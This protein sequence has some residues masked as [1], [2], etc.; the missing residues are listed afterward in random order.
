MKIRIKKKISIYNLA[1]GFVLCLDLLS[2]YFGGSTVGFGWAS[3]L[4]NLG[5]M[6]MFA[7]ILLEYCA[8]KHFDRRT[9]RILLVGGI[10]F[11]G[12]LAVSC[13][14]GID[15]GYARKNLLTICK[16]T[17][18]EISI[19]ML[20]NS[21]HFNFFQEL[22]KN[23][24]LFNFWGFLNMIVLTIQINVKGFM[25]P[26]AWLSMNTYYE[27]LCSGLFGYNGTHRL[28]I[29]M[30]FLFLYNMYFA[31]FEIQK[32]SKQKKLYI[33]NFFLLGWHFMLSTRNDN[34]TIYMLTAI[35]FA[36]YIFMDMHWRKYPIAKTLYKCLKYVAVGLLA[37]IIVFAVPTTREFIMD[38]V[39]KRIMK[40]TTVTASTGSGSTERLSILLYSFENGFGYGIGKGIGYFPFGGDWETNSSVVGF[41]HFGLSS[42]SSL[43]YLLG[44]WF[45][46]FYTLW[47]TKIYQGMCRH[48]DAIFFFVILCIMLFLTF[49][50]TNFTSTP[51]STCLM[52]LFAVF[53]MME[54]KIRMDRTLWRM[55]K[56][57]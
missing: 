45:Y 9:V 21:R 50:T 37:V 14:C 51:M 31:E 3:P 7:A 39:I 26:S 36:A 24:W 33:Y 6:A 53:C 40:L 2:G 1:F 32:E 42:M 46:L 4:W 44:I 15:R 25:M 17:V 41:R 18:A 35:F 49:Y 56:E 30:T 57:N 34:M 22:K 12:F 52:M 8:N 13:I 43:I 23:F 48:K 28:S 19:F 16:V 11:V 55:Q 10:I 47:I 27:D 20:A 38:G 54:E 29:Y 5:I